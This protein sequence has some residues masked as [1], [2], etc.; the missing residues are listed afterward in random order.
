MAS[1]GNQH[2]ANIVSAHFR[3]LYSVSSKRNPRVFS[4]TLL[5]VL[6]SKLQI[7]SHHSHPPVSTLAKD[8]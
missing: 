5:H 3:P 6:L 1:P 7:Q 8:N 4:T 2:C